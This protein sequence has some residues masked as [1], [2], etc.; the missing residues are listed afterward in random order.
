LNIADSGSL[1]NTK[2][3]K[4]EERE[5]GKRGVKRNRKENGGK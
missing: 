4:G 5:G 3:Y 2:L 1:L